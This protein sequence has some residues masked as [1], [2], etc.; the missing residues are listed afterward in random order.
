M[1]RARKR[2]EDAEAAVGCAEEA[3]KAVEAR[4]SAGE[5]APEIFTEHAEATKALENAM[6][7]WELAQIEFDEMN[8]R[9]KS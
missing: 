6:S 8:E 5:S 9:Y 7:V 4:I 2:V 3:V 1:R